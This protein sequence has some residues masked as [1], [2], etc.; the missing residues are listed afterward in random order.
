MRQDVQIS[1]RKKYMDLGLAL[2]I[3]GVAIAAGLAGIGSV[4]GVAIAGQKGAGV[5]TEKPELFGKILLLQALPGSQGIYGFLGAVLIM[6]AVGI[7]GGEIKN[8]T[9]EIGWQFLFA[10]LPVG[11]TGLFSAIYQGKVAAAGLNAIARDGSLAGKAVIMAALVETYAILGLL[12]SIL[13]ISG[14]KIG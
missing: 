13:L 12:V 11:I 9:N 5:M 2:T 14:I 10:S 4:L 6:S 7:L 8:I 3:V 1:L